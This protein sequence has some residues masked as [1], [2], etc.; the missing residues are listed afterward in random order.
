MRR[1]WMALAGIVGLVAGVLGAL[2]V[3]P[4]GERAASPVARPIP[5]D[6]PLAGAVGGVLLVWTPAGLPAGLDVRWRE[7]PGVTAVATVTGGS[8]DLRRSLDGDGRVVD[9]APSGLAIPLDAVA[10][11][12]DR[13]S[14]FLPATALPAFRD[15][16]PG[17]ALLGSTSGRIRRLGAGGVL[18]LVDGS[19]LTVAGVVPDEVIGAAEVVVPRSMLTVVRYALLAYEGDRVA[20]EAAVR[21][22]VP[23]G[24]PVRIRGPGETPFL[25]EG[26]A[27]LPQA[28]I[29]ER[30]GE[31]A[32]ARGAGT[33]VTQDEAWVNQN[34]VAARV[35]LLGLV[36]CHRS[37]IAAL[38]GSMRELE[39]RNLGFLVDPAGF[40]GC[41]VPGVIR[42][43]DALSR[44]AWGVAFDLN[45]AK[46]PTGVGSTQDRRVVD[47]M[48]RWG[49]TSG[50]AWLVPDGSHFEY[51]RPAEP[52]R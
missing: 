24:T 6:V 38:E 3:Q 41:W 25:R 29:K 5:A 49:F 1:V 22:L 34:I 30:F 15:L 26:D 35:L 16:G 46:N 31:F 28:L 9:Q 17:E 37:V 42:P 12:P 2:A 32:Y 48:A 36:R 21:R 13:H 45:T 50:A 23:D 39:E 44:H 4:D 20:V 7:V 27:V 14:P 47:V 8:L 10:V 52:R 51:L 43:G 18:E 40:G 11:D 33:D 19:R